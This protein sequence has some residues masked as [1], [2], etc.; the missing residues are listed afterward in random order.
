MSLFSNL[1][2]IYNSQSLPGHQDLLTMLD[3]SLT[4]LENEV[5]FYRKA[6][7]GGEKLAGGLLDFCKGDDKPVVVVPD[8]HARGYFLLHLLKKEIDIKDENSCVVKMSIIEALEKK[9]IYVV[10]VGDLFHS[11]LRCYGRWKKALENFRNGDVLSL[12][13][14]SEM[15]ENINLLQMI[16]LLK[17]K[18]TEN[19][20]FLKG[21]HENILNEEGKGNHPFYKMAMEGEMVYQFLSTVYDD[22]LIYVLSLWE[23]ALPLCAVFKNLVVSH[24]E[25]AF[26]VNKSK[27]INYRTNPDVVLAL[28]WT[29]NDMADT[30]SVS[31]SVKSLIA[32]NR[33]NVVWIGGHRPV[34]GQYSLR[35]KGK[36]VQIHNPDKEN[37]ALVYPDTK[38]D[39]ENN[40][41]CVNT[42]AG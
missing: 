30:G 10:C 37:I 13:M 38:F 33:K 21:N 42:S 17:E 23:H 25:P 36:F 7:K 4:L 19:F 20:H 6:E 14:K 40:I 32:K 12:E 35:Q 16:L 15:L 3:K 26:S 8:L 9:L 18:C 11:E 31:K 41:I 5:T 39:P 24:A 34:S 27:I 2:N 1:L 22:A 28:T 29:G